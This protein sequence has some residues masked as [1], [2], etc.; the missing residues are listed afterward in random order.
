[1]TIDT[2]QQKSKDDKRPT[3]TP[4]KLETMEIAR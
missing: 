1:M 4:E 2:M 3:E